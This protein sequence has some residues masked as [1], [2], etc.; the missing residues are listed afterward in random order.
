MTQNRIK[1]MK[2]LRSDPEWD[3]LYREKL[4]KASKIKNNDPVAKA[5][6][7]KLMKEKILSGEFTPNITNTWTHWTT[8]I[9]GKKFRSSFE[10]LFYLYQTD[11]KKNTVLYEKLR[12]TYSHENDSKIYIVDFID[13]ASKKVYEIKPD[14]LLL[15]EKNLKKQKSLQKWCEENGFKLETISEEILKQYHKILI[16]NF[17]DDPII[18]FFK[19]KYKW[20]T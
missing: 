6:K 12:I 10:G 17:H 3:R 11:I 1:T 8:E 16:E 5:K 13:E 9:R 15:E 20:N 7:S 2:E 14:S 4:S 19:T 18:E